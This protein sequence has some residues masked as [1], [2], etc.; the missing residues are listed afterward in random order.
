[1]ASADGPI[2]RAAPLVA[3][4]QRARV[5]VAEDNADMR[6]YLARLLAAHWDV[7]VAEDG[8]V[9]LAAARLRAPDLVLSDVMMP[10][11]DGVALVRELRAH[12]H[13]RHVP[14]VLPSA[15]SGEDTMVEGPRHSPDRVGRRVTGETAVSRSRPGSMPSR[16][17]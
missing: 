7:D 12:P 2:P 8:Q 13:T 4:R 6:D 10:R 14:V 9:A 16:H 17:R 11:L 1:V 15:R 3:G 5:L